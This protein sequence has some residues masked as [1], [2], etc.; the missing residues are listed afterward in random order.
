MP[1]STEINKETEVVAYGK[2][3]PISPKKSYE[4]CNALRGL[5]VAKARKFLENIISL[6][7]PVKIRR[8]NQETAHKHP[9]MGPAR[10]PVK[11]AKYI[12]RTIDNAVSN[13]R[14]RWGEDAVDEKELRIVHISAYR[15]SIEK[16]HMPRAHG[17]S[18]EWNEQT[19]N[20]EIKLRKLEEEKEEL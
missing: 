11:P 4:L 13:A 20:V 2:E 17:R 7:Q 9:K 6:K 10:F 12:L 14:Y 1:Y 15:G 16:G 3:H 19:T 5:T 18:S 8:Y